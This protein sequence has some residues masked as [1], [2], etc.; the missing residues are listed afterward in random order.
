MFSFFARA[1]ASAPSSVFPLPLLVVE[2]AVLSLLVLP[3]SLLRLAMKS[4]SSVLLSW[5][6]RSNSFKSRFFIFFRF[7]FL[8]RFSALLNFRSSFR[9]ASSNFAIFSCSF[10]RRSDSCNMSSSCLCSVRH[11][12]CSSFLRVS[13]C[14]RRCSSL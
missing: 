11:L 1:A 2:V 6:C 3:L 14:S 4:W 10:R 5:C 9:R 13:S 12:A 8:R 7:R